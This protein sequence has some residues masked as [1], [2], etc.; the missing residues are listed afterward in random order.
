M[1]KCCWDSSLYLHKHTQKSQ[2]DEVRYSMHLMKIADTVKG[3]YKL[4]CQQHFYMLPPDA[5]VPHDEAST[6]EELAHFGVGRQ[7]V[8]GFPD[9]T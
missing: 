8:L 6:K 5:L 9:L 2:P 4:L 3:K 1:Q 7:D